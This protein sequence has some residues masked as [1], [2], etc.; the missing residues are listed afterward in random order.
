[1]S[2][3]EKYTVLIMVDDQDQVRQATGTGPDPR[4]AV[5]VAWRRLAQD[6][7][8]QLPLAPTDLIP[9]KQDAGQQESSVLCPVHGKAKASK[10]GGFFCPERIDEET[11]CDWT[12]AKPKKKK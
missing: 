7:E 4:Q 12:Y 6:L 8:R 1:M 10:F 3:A 9:P 11:F 5:A 2:A